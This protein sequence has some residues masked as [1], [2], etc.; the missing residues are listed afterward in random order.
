VAQ[1]TGTPGRVGH[2]GRPLGAD[3]D[4]VFGELLGVD[5]DRLGELREKGVL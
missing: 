5:A 1:L 2:L 4:A 3:N